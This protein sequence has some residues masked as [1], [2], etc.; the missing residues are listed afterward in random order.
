[1]NNDDKADGRRLREQLRE[2]T[3]E[4]EETTNHVVFDFTGLDRPNVA[5]LALIL[6]A[7]LGTAPEDSVWVR[8]LPWRTARILEVLR[9]DHLFRHYPEAG[10][11]LN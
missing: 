11:E 6:T 5:D 1:M 9:L 3:P 10:D 2:H 8:S 4:N 7:R